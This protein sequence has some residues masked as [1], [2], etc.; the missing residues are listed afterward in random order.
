MTCVDLWVD[1]GGGKVRR[2]MGQE[3]FVPCGGLLSAVGVVVGGSGPNGQDTNRATCSSVDTL[4]TG[5][6]M[7]YRSVFEP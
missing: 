5:G 1:F 6:S 7:A 3:W 4:G 2:V